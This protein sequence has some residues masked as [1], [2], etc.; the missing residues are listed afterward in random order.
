MNNNT[1]PQP[2]LVLGA[3]TT[4]LTAIFGGLT[5][6]AGLQKNITLALVCGVG[7]VVTAAIN[8]AKD[9]YVRGLVTPFSD[10]AAYRDDSGDIVAG[11]AAAVPDGQPVEVNSVVEGT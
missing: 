5:T 2:V 7:M 10:T 1:K 8:Q 11:P 9:F 6:V 3:V 4:F